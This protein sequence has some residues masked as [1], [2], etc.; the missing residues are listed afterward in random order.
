MGVDALFFVG[1]QTRAELDALSAATK[2]PIILGGGTPELVRPDYLAAAA[3]ASRCRAT[4]PSPP[5]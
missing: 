5:R 2:L 1:V 3:C 4:S